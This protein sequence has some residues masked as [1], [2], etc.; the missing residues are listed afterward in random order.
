[1]KKSFVELLNEIV[2]DFKQIHIKIKNNKFKEIDVFSKI[3]EL[4]RLA[5]E[6]E[7]YTPENISC[8]G[9][10]FSIANIYFC[11]YNEEKSENLKQLEYYYYKWGTENYQDEFKLFLKNNS[12]NYDE[13]GYYIYDLDEYD[14]F[15][16]EKQYSHILKNTSSVNKNTQTIKPQLTF[17]DLFKIPYNT[18]EKITILKEILKN[19][20]YIGQ[21]N[22]WVGIT[23]KKNELA[24]LYD[25][26]N[27]EKNILK[28]ES[29]ELQ[30]KTFYKEFG[31]IVYNDK[32][33]KSGGYCTLR[34]LR[35]TRSKQNETYKNFEIIFSDWVK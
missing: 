8:L 19:N 35:I 27:N 22:K 25:L 26:F 14:I 4:L 1:M 15:D 5:E 11:Y 17:I 18:V 20:V 32:E 24:F 33:T 10:L 7:N 9:N 28:D 21:D 29:F 12:D 13:M 2:N 30:I 23:K 16:Y 6:V 34:N 31:L 3:S